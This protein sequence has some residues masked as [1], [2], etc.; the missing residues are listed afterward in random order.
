MDNEEIKPQDGEGQPLNHPQE[1]DSES[2]QDLSKFFG[3]DDT[4]EEERENAKKSF[5]ET[6]NKMSGKNFK[7]IDALVKSTKEADKAFAQGGVNKSKPAAEPTKETAKP[8][9]MKVPKVVETL[10][11][12]ARPEAKE[13]WEEVEKAAR[14]TG[15]DPFELYESSKY[16]QNEAQALYEEKHKDEEGKSKVKDPSFSPG[17]KGAAAPKITLSDA[18]RALLK[19]RGLSEKDVKIEQ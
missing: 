1:T 5:L 4:S 7:S 3:D 11:F 2:S 19:H 8:E 12:N 17:R 10:Y 18:D 13:V 14:L 15:K 9:P 6:Y 16:F